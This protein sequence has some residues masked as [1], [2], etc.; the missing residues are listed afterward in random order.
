MN[1]GNP[2]VV[3]ITKNETNIIKILPPIIIANQ[4][5]YEKFS[6]FDYFSLIHASRIPSKQAQLGALSLEVPRKDPQQKKC[7][8]HLYLL[9][10]N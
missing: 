7:F 1:E 4:D 8:W 3:L 10:N 6:C 9:G 5:K 2:M